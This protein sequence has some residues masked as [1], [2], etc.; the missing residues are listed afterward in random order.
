MPETSE[1]LHARAAAALRT[2][3]V[4]E[5]DTWPF[6]GDIR[7]KD[8]EPLSPEPVI[9]GQGGED[10]RACQ[11]PDSEY[12]WAGERW[13]LTA[14]PE[15]H[16]LPV[17]VLLEPRKHYAGPAEHLHWWFIGRPEGFGQLRSSFAELWDEVLPP[18]PPEI[19]KDNLDRVVEALNAA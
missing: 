1:Q 10:C 2:P 5:W 13:R 8:L 16:G 6:E 18:T 17:V 14:L 15:P 4:H 7:P 3:S 9:A 11:K 12:L 19:W